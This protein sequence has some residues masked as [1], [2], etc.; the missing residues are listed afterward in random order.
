M[1]R[2]ARRSKLNVSYSLRYC[3]KGSTFIRRPDDAGLLDGSPSFGA[4]RS[5]PSCSRVSI[6]SLDSKSSSESE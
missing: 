6:G 3:E 1:G 2:R 4:T 5:T